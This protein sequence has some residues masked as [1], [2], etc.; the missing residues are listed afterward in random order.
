MGDNTAV[1]LQVE[2]VHKR[3]GGVHAINGCSLT[4]KR[5]TI[6]GLIG[7]NGA[8]KTT[9]FNLISGVLQVDQGDIRYQGESI[10]GL[11]PDRIARRG[12]VRTFQIP[13]VFAHMTVWENLMF[14]PHDQPGEGMWQ[15]LLRTRRMRELEQRHAERAWQVLALVGLETLRD[16]Y[17]ENLSGGQRKLLELARLLMMDPTLILLD[18]P[19]A[20]VNPTLM[21]SLTERI[22]ELNRQGITFLIIEHDM[23]M[24]MRVCNPVIVM[25]QGKTLA[26]GA[27]DEIRHDPR[28]LE[29]Y[30]GE[31]KED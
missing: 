5:G 20:G 7:P 8:G 29:A 19:A 4:V 3:F 23:D 31:V 11:P 28:V 27:P 6:T 1:L 17:A 25:H 9:L 16:E 12:L 13:R 14:A 21:R 30:L 10:V 24:I 22:Q 26:A 18:E 15:A 2:Q